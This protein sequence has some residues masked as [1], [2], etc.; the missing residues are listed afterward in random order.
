MHNKYA[1]ICILTHTC[2]YTQTS[3]EY[4]TLKQHRALFTLEYFTFAH[5]S[6]QATSKLTSQE[7]SVLLSTNCLCE[8]CEIIN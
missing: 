6:F 5:T 1:H 8:S 4:S 7:K 2:I 3:I